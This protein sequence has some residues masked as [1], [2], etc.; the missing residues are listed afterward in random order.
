MN[1][2]YNTVGEQKQYSQL[3]S[4]SKVLYIKK[5]VGSNDSIDLAQGRSPQAETDA[6]CVKF[7]CFSWRANNRSRAANVDELCQGRYERTTE[8]RSSKVFA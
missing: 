5:G 1:V 2:R 3:I 6:L 8:K 4:V 7:S